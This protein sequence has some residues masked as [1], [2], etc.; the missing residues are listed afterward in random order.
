M[1]AIVPGHSAMVVESVSGIASAKMI[2]L[3]MTTMTKMMTTTEKSI[4]EMTL[5]ELY[6]ERDKYRANLL[7]DSRPR[8]ESLEMFEQII[9]QIMIK[10][11]ANQ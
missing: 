3:R 10:E 6:E 7:F 9:R 1:L 5:K 11:V 8:H 4:T 2:H